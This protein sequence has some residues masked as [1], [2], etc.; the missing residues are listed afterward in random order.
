MTLF[1]Q[2][3]V[4]GV[5]IGSVYALVALAIV[6]VFMATET[7][8]LAQGSMGMFSAFVTWELSGPAGLGLPL[9]LGIVAGVV[10]GMLMGAV[11]ER[12]VV[13]PVEAAKDH[14]P[15]IVVTLGIYVALNAL[16]GWLFTTEIVSL[17]SPFPDGALALG[18]VT[19]S[20]VALGMTVS[21]L[22]IA[23]LIWT[24]FFR[25]G[26]GLS[27]RA[28]VDNRV[29]AELVGIRSGR[30]VALAWAIAGG[31][32]ALAAI[33]IAPV[34]QLSTTMMD[35]PL[36]LGVT[37]AALGGLKSPAGA[38]VGGFA[39]GLIQSL[40]PAYIPF[41]GNR[42]ALA[43]VFVVLLVVLLTRPNGLFG[44]PDVVRL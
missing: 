21:C 14:L 13:R 38:L 32:G 2:R 18:G 4:D 7:I 3:T 33:L 27:L 35:N 41:V 19:V 31:V 24:I 43:T 9:A 8:N 12:C 29:S 16:A 26:V 1:L 15:M 42:L 5:A 11:L 23:A 17:P 39:I 20:F 22:L 44:R 25:L 30:I 37:A 36:F 40:A 10:V 34:T 28:V 6:L